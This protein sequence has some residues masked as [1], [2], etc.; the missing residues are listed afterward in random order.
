MSYSI[1]QGD[2]DPPIEFP[3]TVNGVAVDISDVV[4]TPALLWIRPDLSTA[5]VSLIFVD[6]PSGRVARLWQ[7]GDTSIPGLH[8]ARVQVIRAD[9][10]PQTFPSD[11]G[12][13]RWRVAAKPF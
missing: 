1:G 3:L 2:L 12:W 8:R 13:F 7:A 6:K 5:S 4:A 11:N 10:N 9:G